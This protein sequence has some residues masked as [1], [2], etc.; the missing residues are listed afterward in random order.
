MEKRMEISILVGKSPIIFLSG[1]FRNFG[2]KTKISGRM[3][4]RMEISILFGKISILF[5]YQ[6]LWIKAKTNRRMEKKMEISVLLEISEILAEKQ[7]S[8]GECR[9]EWRFPFFSPFSGFSAKISTKKIE[10]RFSKFFSILF[11]KEAFSSP[12]WRKISVFYLKRSWKTLLKKKKNG[13]EFG[14]SP[15]Y[16]FGGD[17]GRK[18]GEW[19][20]EWRS[21]FFRRKSPFFRRKPPF[22][23]LSDMSD[24]LS[25][26]QKS[27]GEWRE[28][29]RSPFFWRKSPFFF[30]A[31]ISEILD[32]KHKSAGEWRKEWRSPFF[33]K[34]SPFFFWEEI[35]EILD[36]NKNHSENGEKNGD[37]HSF[38]EK[39]H[40]FW[41][42]ISENWNEKQ[43]SAGEWR[44]EWRSPFFLRKSANNSENLDEK[45]KPAGEWRKEWRSPFF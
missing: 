39:L 22:F 29:W 6:K 36:E 20:K 27:D 43:K 26:K 19:R 5:F 30:W 44:K 32:E 2:W 17:F 4:K 10:W 45:Q 25:E 40:F 1:N 28:E 24:F 35:S 34:K 23:L 3:E 12:F 13:E 18:T 21:P 9:K 37:L 11:F 15:F 7:E 31:E 16:F 38:W 42:E 41:A 8:L 14:E 33:L